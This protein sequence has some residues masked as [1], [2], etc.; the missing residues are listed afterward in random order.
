MELRPQ[1]TA[2]L[3]IT[4]SYE[5]DFAETV[6]EIVE[7]EKVGVD[8]VS[9]AEAYSFDAVSRLGYL[10]AVTTTMTLTSGILPIFSRT[11]ALIA[12]TAAGLDYVSGGRFELG[13]GTSGAQVI[14]GFHGVPFDA[15]LGHLRENIEIFRTVWKR[16]PLDFHGRY[17][18]APLVEGG[19]GLG[20]PLKLINHPVRENIPI[21][22]AALTPAS[23]AQTAEIANGWVP[24]FFWP[25][26]ADAAWGDSLRK[27]FANR[28]PDLGP[29]DVFASNRLYLGDDP[30]QALEQYRHTLAL[31]IGG[32]GAKGANFYTDLAARYGYGEE[33]LRI[34][35]LYL[36]G[37]K[38]K[39]AEA[40]PEELLRSTSLIGTESQVRERIAAMLEAGVTTISL[41]ALGTTP[42]QRLEHVEAVRA[43][44][45]RV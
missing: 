32:M 25:E 9:V 36:G 19:T 41:T 21:S 27:G 28:H 35:E 26:R 30:D 18:D 43:M 20:K 7:Y 40:V 4:V 29:L 2:R 12:M 31:Y 39:A 33:A 3:G 42:T 24:I 17:Y 6:P 11:P 13:I 22:I 45:P 1:T 14:E 15:P 10:A 16:E 8:L 5:V 38:G 34:Q 37:E 23:V 44:L